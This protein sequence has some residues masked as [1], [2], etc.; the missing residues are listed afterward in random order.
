MTSLID[1]AILLSDR[2]FHE[3][4]IKIVRD[5]LLNNS[6][7][8]DLI[9][10]RIKAR[11]KTLANMANGTDRTQNSFDARKCIT[12]PFVK[13]V[14]EDIRR[15]FNTVHL[16]TVFT[17]PKKLEG[18]I[19]S[20]KDK[21]VRENETE[22]VYQIECGDCDAVYIGQT[23]RHLSTRVNEH[24][25]DITKHPSN[26]SVVSKH[27]MQLGHNFKWEETNI[28]HKEKNIKKREIAEMLLIKKHPNAINLKKDTENLN[29]IYE[30]VIS[31]L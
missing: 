29:S 12:V 23:K 8:I 11:R 24:K 19:K 16:D 6:F 1:R 27:R 20:G 5:I 26:H 18:I 14:G 31:L 30:K 22:L 15:I 28:I 25:K 3:A 9:E 2:R 7:P 10:K 17:I 4:N 21:L 13:G